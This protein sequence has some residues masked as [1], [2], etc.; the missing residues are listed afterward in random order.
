MLRPLW[1]LYWFAKRSKIIQSCCRKQVR[2]WA[3]CDS[4][5][6][7]S[8][9]CSGLTQTASS[10][11]K[12]MLSFIQLRY[13]KTTP[14][15]VETSLNALRRIHLT[16]ANFEWETRPMISRLLV[17]VMYLQLAN[18]QWLTTLSSHR[19]ITLMASTDCP[20]YPGGIWWLRPSPKSECT[21]GLVSASTLC[22]VL[23]GFS[24]LSI[25]SSLWHMPL[26]KIVLRLSCYAA[27]NDCNPTI[28]LQFSLICC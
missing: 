15:V 2:H 3:K 26:K 7:P 1:C 24:R 17:G 23:S 25:S 21:I 8:L 18:A 10:S 5:S 19:R 4:A 12:R 22:D 20:A 9:S 16:G 27:V 14:R 13:C 11:L 6:G 28:S